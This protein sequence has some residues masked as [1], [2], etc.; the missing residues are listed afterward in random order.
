[1]T[2]FLDTLDKI[3]RLDKKLQE[4]LASVQWFCENGSIYEAYLHSLN[5][6]ETAERLVLL[7]RVLPA[8]TGVRNAKLEVEHRI[9]DCIPVEIGFTEE[10]WFCLRI[11]ALLPKKAGGSADYIRSFL[12]PAM[13]AF[14]EKRPPVRYQDCVLIYRHVYDRARP[15]RK[16]RDHDN[17]EI[18][19]V[20]DIVAM[21]VMPDDSPAVCSHYYCST[22]GQEERTEVYVVPKKEFPIWLAMENAMPDEGVELYEKR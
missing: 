20:S 8:Y 2:K 3:G 9:K 5:L 14:F 15:E 18:N 13:R 11:P 10:R 1:M 16:M 21:Y 7:T 4:Q 22:A 19:M 6:E 17:I 12:Y